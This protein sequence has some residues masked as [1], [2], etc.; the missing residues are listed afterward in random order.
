[1][2]RNK[3]MTNNQKYLGHQH[4][5]E[6]IEEVDLEI[7][8]EAV[9]SIFDPNTKKT[10]KKQVVY[11]K[12]PPSW[13]PLTE[14]ETPA[15][16]KPLPMI[17]NNTNVKLILQHLKNHEKESF[18]KQ[19]EIKQEE[20]KKQM[21]IK[22]EEIKKQIKDEKESF[23]KQMEINRQAEI[24]LG[25]IRKQIKEKSNKID[26]NYQK[27]I[28]DL[29]GLFVKVGIVYIDRP[30]ESII[31]DENNYQQKI[32][33]KNKVKMPCLRFKDARYPNLDKARE[34]LRE[35]LTIYTT[36]CDSEYTIEKF[37]EKN[38]I[39]DL[40]Y[41]KCKEFINRLKHQIQIKRTQNKENNN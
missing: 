3:L 11:F 9:E 34:E 25:E 18:K 37:E 27:G 20:I 23:K 5:P 19:M 39:D 10:S 14:K 36:E 32:T 40:N 15:E 26:L 24:K 17:V 38:K 7:E 13:F 12:N 6:G 30:Q 33:E 1:M 21:E 16:Q 8:S 31:F 29:T 28:F 22:Q 41:A 4:F 35:L 2:K